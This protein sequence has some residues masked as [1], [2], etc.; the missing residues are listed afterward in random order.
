MA[1]AKNNSPTQATGYIMRGAIILAAGAVQK[2]GEAGFRSHDTSNDPCTGKMNSPYEC[3]VKAPDF[4]LTG[5]AVVEAPIRRASVGWKAV[6]L[7]RVLAFD[8]CLGAE[9]SKTSLPQHTSNVDY[10]SP[11][12]H[13]RDHHMNGSSS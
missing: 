8:A 12:D 11:L 10:I 1:V 4:C 3:I 2:R 7:V 9:P 6:Q 13:A 5:A